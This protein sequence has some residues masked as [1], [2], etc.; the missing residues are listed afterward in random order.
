[1]SLTSEKEDTS[2]ISWLLALEANVVL[3][4][5]RVSTCAV[6]AALVVLLLV[7]RGQSALEVT[8][9]SLLLLHEEVNQ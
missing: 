5:T 9:L 4:R 6:V 2:N 7:S 8:D 1:M 3:L